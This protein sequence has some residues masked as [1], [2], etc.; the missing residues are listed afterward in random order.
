ML[1]LHS[2]RFISSFGKVTPKSTCFLWESM[3]LIVF[4][5][6][7]YLLLRKHVWFLKHVICGF[8]YR[9]WRCCDLPCLWLIVV[10]CCLRKRDWSSKKKH[11]YCGGCCDGLFLCIMFIVWKWT[12]LMLPNVFF[13]VVVVVFSSL[14]LLLIVT[15]SLCVDV[16]LCRFLWWLSL[17]VFENGY[18]WCCKTCSLW[19]YLSS[20]S[21]WYCC[22]LLF[23]LCALMYF[24]V[25]SCDDLAC[26]CLKIDMLDV[27]KHVFCGSF[28]RFLRF[29]III[30]CHFFFVL[31][32]ISLLLFA[33]T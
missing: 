31:W 22:W 20:S 24:F 6:T 1:F 19:W 29:D 26:F 30:D 18:V 12:C 5:S 13:V 11:V 7:E 27:A 14:M 3:F 16:F 8:H 33:M 4:N 32:C 9:C 10:Y 2:L 23:F 25:S 21:P 28:C 15:F 17:F